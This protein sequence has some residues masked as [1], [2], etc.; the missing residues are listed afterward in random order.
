MHLTTHTDYALRTLI[1]LAVGKSDS[2]TSVRE[3]AEHYGISHAHLVKVAQGLASGGFIDTRAGRHG[4]MRLAS[5]PEELS[6]GAVVR[7]MEPLGLVACMRPAEMGT[8][9]IEAAC[10]L[11]GV[12]DRAV[13]AFLA[14]L[15]GVNLRMCIAKPRLA[16]QLLQIRTR[17]H[18]D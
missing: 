7:H 12:L 8:C 18:A 9:T 5:P 1:Y 3:V 10:G 15:D 6:V 11:G 17:G 16:Q 2:W 13:A 4:G 14:E